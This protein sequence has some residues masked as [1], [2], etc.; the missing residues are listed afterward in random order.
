MCLFLGD[1]GSDRGAREQLHCLFGNRRAERHLQHH[2]GGVSD[3]LLFSG[4]RRGH[5][6]QRVSAHLLQVRLERTNM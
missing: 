3:L 6:P 4:A 5:R 1:E 2:R